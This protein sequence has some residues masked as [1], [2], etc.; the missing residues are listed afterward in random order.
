MLAERRNLFK[1]KRPFR[2]NLTAILLQI[3]AVIYTFASCVVGNGI[4]QNHIASDSSRADNKSVAVVSCL[5][6]LTNVA[7]R[8]TCVVDADS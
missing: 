5:F 4:R 7:W 2:D 8:G 1:T 3:K 6:A